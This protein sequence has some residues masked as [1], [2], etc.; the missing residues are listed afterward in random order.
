MHT[1]YQRDGEVG[2]RN[3]EL[4]EDVP[5][6]I[7]TA[8]SCGR[9]AGTVIHLSWG[10]AAGSKVLRVPACLRRLRPLLRLE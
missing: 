10:V 2:Y 8:S 7:L 3:L 4:P 1:L 6:G 5:V 9:L